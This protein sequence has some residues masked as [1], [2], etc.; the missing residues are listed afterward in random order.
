[1]GKD[2]NLRCKKCGYRGA[3]LIE[4]AVEQERDIIPGIYLPDKGAHRHLT[5]PYERY[6]REKAIQLIL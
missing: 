2:Q 5:K 1:M 4:Q 6:E 3:D